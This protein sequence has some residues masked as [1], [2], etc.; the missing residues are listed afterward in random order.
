MPTFGFTVEM[1]GT[2]LSEDDLQRLSHCADALF[3]VAD[4]VAFGDFSREA[5]SYGA[6]VGTAIQEIENALPGARVV[7]VV[8]HLGPLSVTG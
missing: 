3:G 4:G 7:R 1:D 5:D 6:A 2:S 8:R